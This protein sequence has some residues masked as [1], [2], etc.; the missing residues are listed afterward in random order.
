[1]EHEYYQVQEQSARVLGEQ[2]RLVTKPGFAG[3]HGISPATELLAEAVQAPEAAQ[4]A[5][6]E[7]AAGAIGV[8]L[9]R[10]YPQARLTLT[11]SN[12][13]ALAMAERTLRANG[14]NTATITPA[15]SLAGTAP[16]SY[17]SVT[18]EL[19]QSRAAVRRRLVEA[20]AIVRPGGNVYLA[21]PNELGIQSSIDDM[22]ALFGQ[23]ALLTYRRHCRVARATR[24]DTLP[25]PPAWVAEEGI[26]PGSWIPLSIAG[27]Q[28]APAQEHTNL[29]AL[30]GVFSAERLDGGTA[31]LLANMPDPRGLRVLDAGCGYGPIGIAALLRGAMHAT[32]VD[33]DQ[34][35]IAATREN[36]ARLGLTN[37]SA[38]AGDALA[39][40]AQQQYDLILSNPPFHTGKQVSYDI[41]HVFIRQSRQL[42]ARGGRLV[43]VANRFL[44][45]DRVMA[46]VFGDVTTLAATRQFHVLSGR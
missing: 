9:A 3:W 15:I 32:L 35:A 20:L 19:P 4:I 42:L 45:Y 28:L 44:R 31:L 22:R 43:L 40:V 14:V 30:P 11:A 23:A 38:I 34:W 8:A 46:E 10:R 29:V 33:S 24:T 7:C 1:M 12:A 39:P 26:Q 13:I 41:A 6:L 16:G 17:D 36:L 21:G 18:I 37:A 27:L 5:A 25:A 2:I